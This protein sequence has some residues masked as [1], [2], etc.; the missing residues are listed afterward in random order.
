MRDRKTYKII[1]L[2]TK[3]DNC[4]SRIKAQKIIK[5]A[6]KLNKPLCKNNI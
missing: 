4:T 1:K 3:A 6:E 5:K 2:I